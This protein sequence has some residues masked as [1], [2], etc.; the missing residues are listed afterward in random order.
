MFETGEKPMASGWPL[1][2]FAQPRCAAAASLFHS[3]KASQYFSTR[4]TNPLSGHSTNPDTHAVWL[5][6]FAEPPARA[7]F[8]ARWIGCDTNFANIGQQAGQAE[9]GYLI[10]SEEIAPHGLLAI[11]LDLGQRYLGRTT[12]RCRLSPHCSYRDC[13]LIRPWTRDERSRGA[14]ETK[15]RGREVEREA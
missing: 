7:W 4:L 14:Q 11:T 5:F 10:G 12:S 8:G 1:I 3:C 15:K 13:S 9:K 2:P 6:A